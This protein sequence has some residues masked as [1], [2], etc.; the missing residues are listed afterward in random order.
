M[1]THN[2]ILVAAVAMLAVGC[3]RTPD[4]AARIDSP[5]VAAPAQPPPTASASQ[6]SFAYVDSTG[7][8]LLALDSVPSP[9]T[10]R[11]ALC[12]G[13]VALPVRYDRRQARQPSDNGRQMAYNFANQQGD[14]FRVLQ[15]RA[16]PNKTCYLSRDSAL[17]ANA[18]PATMHEPS[19]C[20]PAQAIRLA[21][22]KARQVIHCWKIGA[23]PTNR[24]V[25][26]VQFATVDSSAL[27]AIIIDGDSALL[28]KDFPAV[29]RGPDDSTWRVDDGG[30]FS[31]QDLD[32]LFSAP[33][34]S[35]YVMAIA[36]AGAEGES[37]ELV[38]ADS[39]GVFRTA[40]IGYRY[41]SPI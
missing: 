33:S 26:A 16:P 1:K 6:G 11:G 27:A 18:R 7:T 22:A 29:Y 3:D 9:S 41:W 4:A 34:P 28:V 17:L 23:T 19:D 31:P 32:I 20:S 35:G 2:T 10:V 36:W 21:A 30:V 25:F 8:Q 13:G 39:T 40:T 24:E 15:G 5:V 38:V 37:S 12:F 14:V